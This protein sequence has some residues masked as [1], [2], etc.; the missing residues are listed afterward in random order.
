MHDIHNTYINPSPKSNTSQALVKSIQL[1]VISI[2]IKLSPTRAKPII[3]VTTKL[4][5]RINLQ[6]KPTISYPTKRAY[7]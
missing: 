3:K 6:K 1:I 7:G 4:R 5:H 2:T